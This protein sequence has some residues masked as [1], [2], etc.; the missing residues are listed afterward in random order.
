VSADLDEG[1]HRHSGR[2]RT[3]RFKNSQARTVTLDGGERVCA[4]AEM[5]FKERIPPGERDEWKAR[6]KQDHAARRPEKEA[7]VQRKSSGPPAKEGTEDAPGVAEAAEAPLT[8]TPGEA[9]NESN[10][11]GD[12][13]GWLQLLQHAEALAKEKPVSCI[14]LVDDRKDDWW[15]LEPVHGARVPRRLGPLPALVREYRER[16]GK[17]FQMYLPSQFLELAAKRGILEVAVASSTISEL[18]DLE[19][20]VAAV[21]KAP[22]DPEKA[23]DEG[24]GDEPIADGPKGSKG[25]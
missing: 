7:K 9:K 20:N 17:R 1:A 10:M 25:G 12:C 14:F 4:L 23:L 13:L 15:H 8:Q 16:C 3:P 18:K 5:R 19:Q 2:A 6:R 24:N 21:A 22:I 11:F